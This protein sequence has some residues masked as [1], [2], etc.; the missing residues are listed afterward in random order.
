M[1]NKNKYNIILLLI[2][3]FLFSKNSYAKVAEGQNFDIVASRVCADVVQELSN[4]NFKIPVYSTS[5]IVIGDISMPGK[6]TSSVGFEMP[7][8]NSITSGGA[9]GFVGAVAA[10]YLKQKNVY[11]KNII[12]KQDALGSVIIPYMWQND[13]TPYFYFDI[14]VKALAPQG[15]SYSFNIEPDNVIDIVSNFLQI[16]EETKLPD[17]KH[18]FYIKAIINAEQ[19]SPVYSVE[20]WVDS[21][22]PTITEIIPA[23]GEAVNN[24]MVPIEITLEDNCSGINENT[25]QLKLNNQAVLFQ[26]DPEIAKIYYTPNNSNLIE[27]EN[28]LTLNMADNLLNTTPETTVSFTID[29]IA[30][31]G[32]IKINAGDTTTYS[33][34]VDLAFT[35]DG[36]GT[37]V[38]AMNINSTGIF[39]EAEW[40]PYVA[41]KE[42]W[43]ISAYSGNK[44][45]YIKFRDAAGN[46]SNIY[47]DSIELISNA[48]DTILNEYPENI[49][50][51]TT[52]KFIYA[53]SMANAVFSY[54]LDGNNWSLWEAT[55]TIEF[56]DLSKGNHYFFVKSAV[57]LNDNYQ[58]DEDEIDS[59]PVYT[60]W[61]ITDEAGLY[62]QESSK[63]KDW[64]NI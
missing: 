48:P 23:G 29:T 60:A 36:T 15:Y 26:Y 59:I 62:Q 46:L 4:E 35:A 31:T 16:T 18:T 33:S 8:S 27:G 55:Q 45:V 37:D 22:P 53:S 56:A 28:K 40:I 11:I 49:T 2:I 10:A 32:T 13:A 19:V 24:Y 39:K 1:L 57:D 6:Y 43:R 50:A 9:V 41:E 25:I 20:I 61:L 64:V 12:I 47:S 42:S 30:P 17:G 5:E 58:I 63:V 14:P 38:V 21:Q 52:A 3:L 34:F 7:L 54:K 51:E 44:I